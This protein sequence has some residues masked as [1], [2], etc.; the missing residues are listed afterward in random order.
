MEEMRSDR[1]EAKREMKRPRSKAKELA[2]IIA[3]A[4]LAIERLWARQEVE[5]RAKQPE[6]S[7][8]IAKDNLR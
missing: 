1:V 2:P 3:E 5:D 7:R 6:D 4:V 8:T